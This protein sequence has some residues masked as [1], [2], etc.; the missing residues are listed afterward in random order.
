MLK[1]VGNEKRFGDIP[2]VFSGD[3]TQLEPVGARPVYVDPNNTLWFDTVTTFIELKTNHRFHVDQEWGN[4]LSNIRQ[5]GAS[6]DDLAK[7]NTRVVDSN[8]INESSIPSDAVYATATNLDKAAINDGIFSLHI[9]KTHS[10]K[11]KYWTPD[12]TI[13]IKASNVS[14]KKKNAR[15]YEKTKNKFVLD[16]IHGTCCNAHLVDTNNKRHDPMLKLYKNRPLCINQNLDVENCVANGAMCKFKGIILTNN[17]LSKVETMSMD[18][19]YVKCVEACYVERIVVE[20]IDGNHD[21]NNPKIIHL[22]KKTVQV[23]VKFPMPW[24]GPI[25]SSTRRISRKIQLD[26]FPVNVADARTVHKLQGRSIN[27]LVIS[28]WDYKG[29]WVY[30]VLSRYPTMQGLFLRRKLEKSRGMSRRCIKFHEEFRE[31]KNQNYSH[32]F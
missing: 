11:N 28:N 26:Q 19:Y 23:T 29:N 6:E 20:M 27:N 2:I 32:I 1:E 22:E 7:I 10:K 5:D 21:P 25:K 9:S 16:T 17:G 4:L 15:G 3:F 13:C 31:R 18:G 14:F 24:D 12:H 8:H 30:M